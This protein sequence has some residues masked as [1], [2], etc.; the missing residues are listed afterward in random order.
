MELSMDKCDNN[1]IKCHRLGCEGPSA[2]VGITSEDGDCSM[3]GTTI[4]AK[5]ETNKRLLFLYCVP[6]SEAY[7]CT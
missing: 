3:L 4:L 2:G 5:V 6:K 1:L 7:I